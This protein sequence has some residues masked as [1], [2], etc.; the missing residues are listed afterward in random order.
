MCK[1]F[2]LLCDGTGLDSVE[3]P[4]V[5]DPS[6]TCLKFLLCNEILNCLRSVTPSD[7]A[8]LGKLYKI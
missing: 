4:L 3:I 2:L 5:T 8:L 7:L 6:V 1:Y